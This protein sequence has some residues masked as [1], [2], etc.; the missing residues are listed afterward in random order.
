MSL[1]ASASERSRCAAST[2]SDYASRCPGAILPFEHVRKRKQLKPT[3][4]VLGKTPR[5]LM[6]TV[7]DELNLKFDRDDHIRTCY[8]LRH[9]YVCLRLLEGADIYQ[10]VK[11]CRTSVEMIEKFDG[12]HLKNN[13]DAPTVNVR[14][15][16]RDVT[17]GARLWRCAQTWLRYKQLGR[18][19]G[20]TGRRAGFKIQF[21]EECG[22]DSH[23]PHHPTFQAP[24]SS[25]HGGW[26]LHQ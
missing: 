22:F 10:V 6:N 21:R 26:N 11:N 18:G 20:G 19:R 7:V 14:N 8:S 25:P 15:E 12:R 9:P 3:D 2:G 17:R 16:A 5:E 13:I 4:I 24:P 1:P 23:R